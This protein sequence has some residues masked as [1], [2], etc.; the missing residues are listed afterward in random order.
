MPWNLGIA[1]S[2]QEGAVSVVS[3][4]MLFRFLNIDTF[5]SMCSGTSPFQTM[6]QIF[7]QENFIKEISQDEVLEM[8]YL[9]GKG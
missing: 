9:H 7:F 8:D 1:Y 2:Y 5:F 6:E 4:S 3:K